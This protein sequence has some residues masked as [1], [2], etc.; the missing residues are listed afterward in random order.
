VFFAKRFRRRLTQDVPAL[1]LIAARRLYSGS[2]A[3]LRNRVAILTLAL[4]LYT[5]IIG[6]KPLQIKVSSAAAVDGDPVRQIIYLGVTALLM[7]A[8]QVHRKPARLVPFPILISLLLLWCLVS[9]SWSAVPGI[10]VRRLLLTFIVMWSIFRSVDEVGYARTVTVLRIGL[11]AALLANFLAVA[12]S[13]VAVHQVNE[14]AD[15]KLVGNWR[16]FLPHKNWAGPLC[17]VTIILFLFDTR[18]LVGRYRIAQVLI[19]LGS[20]FFLYKTQSKTSMSLLGVSMAVGFLFQRYNPKYRV[21]LVPVVA[22]LAMAA[23]VFVNAHRD[24]LLAPFWG[25][26]RTVLT[27]R[28]DIWPLLIDYWTDHP[29]GAGFGSF[30]KVGPDSPIN[31]YTDSWVAGVGNGHNGYLDLLVTIGWPGLI[32]AV[33]ATVISP[34]CRLMMSVKVSRAAR[35]MLMALLIFCV[36]QNGTETSLLDRDMLMQVFF[37][38]SVALIYEASRFSDVQRRAFRSSEITQGLAQSHTSRQV[39]LPVQIRGHE[40]GV[41]T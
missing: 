14:L 25:S 10:A 17:S 11:A 40:Q 33:L 32:L 29:L 6:T 20:G 7:W 1:V 18:L 37:M 26:D 27:G 38:L 5:V 2:N 36:A 23:A 19:L 13:P 3:A 31:H 12:L 39:Q 24:K 21:F 22:S 41:R 4:I 15:P 28:V 16:G 8:S 9:I 35:G 30:W 34:L